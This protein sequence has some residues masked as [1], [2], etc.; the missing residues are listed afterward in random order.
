MNLQR[1]R[2][3][4]ERAKVH[5]REFGRIWHEFL[6]GDEAAAIT[7]SRVVEAAVIEHEPYVARVTV[8]P[9]GEGVIEIEP[10]DL[11]AEQL[12]L[13]FGEFLYQL[14][15]S[16]DSLVYE[17]AIIDSRQDPPPDAEKLEFPI[18]RSKAS[19]DEAA[20]KIRPL[21][22][23]HRWM[24]ESMQPYDLDDLAPGMRKTAE[25]L[26]VVNDLARKDRHRGMR[27]VASWGSSAN[28]EFDLP[29]RCSLDWVT[30]TQDGLFESESEVARFKIANWTPDLEMQANPNLM[31][32]VTVEDFTPASGDDE[33]TLASQTRW[34]LAVFELLFEGFE[35]TLG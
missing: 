26:A 35:K 21:N 8:H 33:D 11:P 24:I 32:D 28:P 6:V 14:R 16:L 17:L 27:V 19:F 22:D 13:E 29:D 2:A 5:H 12:S 31:I 1:P 18:R 4:L 9:D 23:Q 30:V 15:A 7:D 25:T 3:R 20:W 34:W 10:V